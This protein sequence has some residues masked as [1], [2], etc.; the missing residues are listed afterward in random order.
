MSD[1]RPAGGPSIRIPENNGKNWYWCLVA[2]C[3]DDR[4]SVTLKNKNKILNS[5]QK[6]I[7]I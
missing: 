3:M 1:T 2:K 6:D 5:I 4:W 7:I